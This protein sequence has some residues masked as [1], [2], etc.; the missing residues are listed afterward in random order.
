MAAVGFAGPV[1]T[2]A[3]A[4]RAWRGMPPTQIDHKPTIAR[5]RRPLQVAVVGGG[6][7]DVFSIAHFAVGGTKGSDGSALF[8]E[9]LERRDYDGRSRT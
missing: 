2:T 5:A 9:P 1:A 7:S 8:Y 4:F 6:R 3:M